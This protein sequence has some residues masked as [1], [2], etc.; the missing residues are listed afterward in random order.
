M[1]VHEKASNSIHL[2]Y[3]FIRE[4]DTAYPVHHALKMFSMSLVLFTMEYRQQVKCTK[5]KQNN[6]TKR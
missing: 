3:A 6:M 5:S 4:C 1:F 2:L